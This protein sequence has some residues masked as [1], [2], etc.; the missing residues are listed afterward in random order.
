M[1]PVIRC[2]IL[3][4]CMVIYTSAVRFHCLCVKTNKTVKPSLIIELKEYKA[5]PYCSKHEAIAILKGNRSVC[6]D[7]RGKFTEKVRR[8]LAMRE[9]GAKMKLTTEH[10][11]LSN[12]TSRPTVNP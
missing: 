7:P 6:L 1:N 3:L 9:K 4:A 11:Q 5:R 2:F 10:P 12:G 8:Y